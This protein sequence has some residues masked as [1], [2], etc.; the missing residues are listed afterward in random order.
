MRIDNID[1][2]RKTY[3]GLPLEDAEIQEVEEFILEK[4]REFQTEQKTRN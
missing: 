2:V 4:Y 1:P 3:K